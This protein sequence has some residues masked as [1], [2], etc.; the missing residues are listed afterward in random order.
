V[1]RE[2]DANEINSTKIE[3]KTAPVSFGF[4]HNNKSLAKN[5]KNNRKK[6]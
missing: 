5:V 2:N 4:A 1:N 3:P 6:I